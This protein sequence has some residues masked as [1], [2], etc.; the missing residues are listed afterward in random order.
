MGFTQKL[1]LAFGSVLFIVVLSGNEG[2]SSPSHHFFGGKPAF[3]SI[4]NL[5]KNCKSFRAQLYTHTGSLESPLGNPIFGDCSKGLQVLLP[6][7]RVKT[8][9]LVQIEISSPGGGSP[10]VDVPLMVYP[11]DILNPLRIWAER[12]ELVVSDSEGKLEEFFEQQNIP[13]RSNRKMMVQTPVVLISTGTG[14]I[15][16]KEE[17]E[18]FPR[19]VY[20]EKKIEVEIPFLDSL[21][22]NP[23]FQIELI[24]MFENIL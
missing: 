11:K 2:W 6:E 9:L 24:K 19:I 18:G 1:S 5:S 4:K 15:I 22:E 12:N 17:T 10:L 13:F 14:R 7:V 8:E 23:A 20:K 16:F 3:L 21:S